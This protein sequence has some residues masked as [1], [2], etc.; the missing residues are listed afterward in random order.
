MQVRELRVRYELTSAAGFP[1][2]H[3]VVCQFPTLMVHVN[4]IREAG[5]KLLGVDER[6]RD[7][8]DRLELDEGWQPVRN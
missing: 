6:I 7:E 8:K 5:Y 1:V 2:V 4:K 3:A